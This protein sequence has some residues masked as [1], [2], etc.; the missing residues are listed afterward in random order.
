MVRY[1]DSY[2]GAVQWIH[3]RL[4]SCRPGFKS[5]VH[6]LCFHQYRF[7]LCNVE[8]TKINKRGQYWPLF[9]KIESYLSKVNLKVLIRHPRELLA[10]KFARY[11]L[12][13]RSGRGHD[14]LIQ[15]LHGGGDVVHV[16][17]VDPRLDVRVEAQLAAVRV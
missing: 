4:P 11:L 12:Q 1:P 13:E 2:L 15:V 17:Q 5:Q 14:E 7:E 16:G 6:H 8:K 3:L 10:A 9:K